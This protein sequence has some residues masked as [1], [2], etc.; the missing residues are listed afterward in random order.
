MDIEYEEF[1]EKPS[2]YRFIHEKLRLIAEETSD[3]YA[4]LYSCDCDDSTAYRRFDGKKEH[5]LSKF[6]WRIYG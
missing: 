3:F 4:I 5:S 6:D 1:S 2:L